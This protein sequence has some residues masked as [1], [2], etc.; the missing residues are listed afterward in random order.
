MAQAGRG[1][2]VVVVLA[3]VAGVLAGA[4]VVTRNTHRI[5]ARLSGAERVAFARKVNAIRR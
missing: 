4:G 5:V 1:V 2:I 3:F